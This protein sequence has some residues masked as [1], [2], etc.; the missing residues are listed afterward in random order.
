MTDRA[1][2]PAS[3]GLGA[4]SISEETA[5]AAP[6]PGLFSSTPATAFHTPHVSHQVNTSRQLEEQR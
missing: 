6:G 2:Q 5:A 1:L 4:I 3:P